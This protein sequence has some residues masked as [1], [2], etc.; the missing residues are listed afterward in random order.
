MR[1]I[2][3]SSTGEFTLLDK[4]QK[5]T[6]MKTIGKMEAMM[7]ALES[8]VSMDIQEHEFTIDDF[9]ELLKKEGKTIQRKT[10]SE[11]LR[12]L[13]S[14]GQLKAR[15]VSRNGKIHNVYSAP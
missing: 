3:R 7:A 9:C 14:N 5:Y 4:Q 8:A 6:L 15:K 10:A 13:V 2:L 12:R 1:G 11:H